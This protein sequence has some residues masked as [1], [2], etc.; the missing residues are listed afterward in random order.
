MGNR[1]GS[2]PAIRRKIPDSRKNFKKPK[3]LSK[4]VLTRGV[5]SGIIHRL[6]ARA[7]VERAKANELEKVS[8]NFQ[9]PL[10][11]PNLLWYNKKVAEIE[12]NK[13]LKKV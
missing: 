10:D 2:T 9:K 8:K 1:A 4:K 7:A 11:K 13:R 12:R 5:V 3:K 6:S